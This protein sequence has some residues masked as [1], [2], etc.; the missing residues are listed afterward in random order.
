MINEIFT[1]WNRQT[2]GTKIWSYL[3]GI[4]IGEDS[5]GNIYYRNKSDTR[6]WVIY[7]GQVEAT[8]VTPEWNNWLRFTSINKPDHSDVFDWQLNHMSNQTG[9]L[10]S[11]SPKSSIFNNKSEYKKKIDYVRWK[12]KK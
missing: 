1:W 12:P 8:E 6:R 9:T 4:K 3:Y 2:L 10:N 11:Y 5:R 7:C